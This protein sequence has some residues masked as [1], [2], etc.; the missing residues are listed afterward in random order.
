[1][2][3]AK[4]MNTTPYEIATSVMDALKGRASVFYKTYVS[5]PGPLLLICSLFI[6]KTDPWIKAS[7]I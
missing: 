5:D 1:M 6:N 2:A 4:H 3:I 7:L